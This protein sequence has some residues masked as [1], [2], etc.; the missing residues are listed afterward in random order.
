M[1]RAPN[2]ENYVVVTFD[3]DVRTD[4]GSTKVHKRQYWVR[5]DGSWKIL[6]EGNA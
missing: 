3:Q 5:E 4:N 1:F 2:T 6:F